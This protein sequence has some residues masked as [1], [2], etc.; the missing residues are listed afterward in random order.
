MIQVIKETT[1]M[2]GMLGDI[3]KES[4]KMMDSLRILI[5]QNVPKEHREE[6]KRGLIAD[7]VGVLFG[8]GPDIEEGT[9]HTINEKTKKIETRKYDK[10]TGKWKAQKNWK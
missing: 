9:T 5:D 2:T 8:E 3:L 1:T 10:E 4:V 7:Y 6:L